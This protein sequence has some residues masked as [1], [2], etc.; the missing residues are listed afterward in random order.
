MLIETI[1]TTTDNCFYHSFTFYHFLPVCYSLKVKNN[2][3]KYKIVELIRSSSRSSPIIS[4]TCI[5][6]QEMCRVDTQGDIYL[7]NI[8]TSREGI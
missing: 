3:A 1:D 7:Y 8:K 5:I 6:L 2:A 4:L